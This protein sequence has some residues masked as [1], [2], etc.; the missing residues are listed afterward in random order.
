MAAAGRVS[1][2][3]TGYREALATVNL[4]GGVSVGGR[5]GPAYMLSYNAQGAMIEYKRWWP[6]MTNNR[7]NYI[8]TYITDSTREDLSI[9]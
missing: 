9:G 6:R 4:A 5:V 7:V 2:G 1:N 3:A 8:K